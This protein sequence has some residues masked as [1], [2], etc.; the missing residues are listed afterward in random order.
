MIRKIVFID[1]NIVKDEYIF[2]DLI[3][4]QNLINNNFK[5]SDRKKQVSFY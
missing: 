3:D 5:N 1:L 4:I 2:P